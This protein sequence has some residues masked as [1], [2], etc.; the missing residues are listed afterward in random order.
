MLTASPPAS[1]GRTSCAIRVRVSRSSSSGHRA[2]IASMPAR[3]QALTL[4]TTSA[5]RGRL[6]IVPLRI[7]T[8]FRESSSSRYSQ[9]CC[10]DRLLPPA[11]AGRCEPSAAGRRRAL[12]S[13]RRCNIT[14]AGFG[15]SCRADSTRGLAGRCPL[16]CSTPTRPGHDEPGRADGCG[17]RWPLGHVARGRNRR[18][19][20][21]LDLILPVVGLQD[22]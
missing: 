9:V 5:G 15:H 4:S 20:R 1:C 13:S 14:V 22:A 6:E 16:S 12:P 2:A 3:V 11:S 17:R 8:S 18:G 7:G 21:L 10:G 19:L